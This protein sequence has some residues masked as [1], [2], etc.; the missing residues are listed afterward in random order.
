MACALINCSRA[1]RLCN[2]IVNKQKKP[3]SSCTL[4]CDLNAIIIILKVLISGEKEETKGVE[5]ESKQ[6]M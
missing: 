2:L 1:L 6:K 5:R 3:L 4:I